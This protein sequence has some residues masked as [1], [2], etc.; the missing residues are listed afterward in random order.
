M[1]KFINI[2][3]TTPLKSLEPSMKAISKKY[4]FILRDDASFPYLCLTED[5]LELHS[6]DDHH[7]PLKPLSV[8]FLSTSLRSRAKQGGGTKQALAKAVGIKPG[9][10]PSVIDGTAGFGK[11]GFLLAMLGCKVHLIER[12]PVMAALLEDGLQRAKNDSIVGSIVKQNIEMTWSDLTEYLKGLPEPSRPDTIYLDPMFSSRKKAALTKLELRIIRDIVGHN[13]DSA[14]LLKKSL[15]IA[16]KR[17]VV[18][19]PKLNPPLAG[20]EPHHTL[21]GSSIS[22]DVYLCGEK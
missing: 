4:G 10:R 2:P 21:V 13:E 20:S 7:K 17:V 15:A 8:N 11:D 16:K 19:R 14:I 18:K 6:E 1:N 12:S 5:A 9:F 22:F 3:I